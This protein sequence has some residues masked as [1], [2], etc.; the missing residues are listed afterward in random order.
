MQKKEMNSKDLLLSFL[1][2]P[3]ISNNY[4]E[5]IIGRTKLTKMM[6][7]FEKEI[8]GSFFKGNIEIVLPEFEAYYFGPFSKQLLEDLYFFLSIGMIASKETNIPLSAADEVEINGVFDDDIDEDWK[9]ASFGN[10]QKSFEM[11][12]ELSQNGQRYV[13][14]RVWD[15]FTSTQKEIL[16]A[17]K[18]Q[19]NKISLDA[20]LRYVYTKYPDDA[21]KS[22][23]A[24][25]YLDKVE[26]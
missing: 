11:S 7:L 3:G 14:E 2:S 15:A 20:L 24:D 19:I 22:L 6:Y 12:Y 23:I 16:K 5:P 26:D 1:Y 21:K 13:R 10:P 17:F 9:E 4:N 8:Y 25:K 18:G